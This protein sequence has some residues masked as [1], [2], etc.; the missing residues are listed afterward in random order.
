MRDEP[1]DTSNAWPAGDIQAAR[2]RDATNASW[3]M[4]NFTPEKGSNMATAASKEHMIP[5]TADV[6]ARVGP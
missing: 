4:K 6:L 1:S 5:A 2:S 3:P